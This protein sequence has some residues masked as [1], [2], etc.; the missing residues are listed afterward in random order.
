MKHA[1]REIAGAR[2][3]TTA[4]ESSIRRRGGDG[5]V[6]LARRLANDHEGG[7]ATSR[8][9][10]GRGLARA[11]STARRHAGSTAWKH[12]EVCVRARAGGTA[13]ERAGSTAWSRAGSTAGS[14]TVLSYVYLESTT[15]EWCHGTRP[16]EHNT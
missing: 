15:T 11:G 12:A 7:C 1:A 14:W 9:R 10:A 6:N 16:N 13:R 3:D 8:T 4:M 5:D 2:V